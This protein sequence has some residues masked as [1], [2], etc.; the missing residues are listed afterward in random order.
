MHRFPLSCLLLLLTA[1]C[2]DKARNA[3]CDG[4]DPG[5]GEEVSLQLAALGYGSFN[6]DDTGGGWSEGTE[7]LTEEVDWAAYTAQLGDDGGLT[8]DFAT[9]VVFVHRWGDGGC[10]PSYQYVAWRW[11]E[12]VRVRGFQDG[13]DG[14]CDAYFPQTDLVL[15]PGTAGADLD[16]CEDL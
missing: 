2:A 12:V 10:E 14:G 15:L 5:E 3:E 8:P 1:A 4:N 9:D 13:K 7:I 16:W 6:M 11:G